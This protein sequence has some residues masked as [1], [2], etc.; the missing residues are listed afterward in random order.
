MSGSWHRRELPPRV[1]SYKGVPSSYILLDSFSVRDINK[2]NN[3][4]DNIL[5]FHWDYYQC[6]AF[7]RLKIHDSIEKS[8]LS[9]AGPFRFSKW[10]RVV[11]Y[12]YSLD[13]FSTV[14]TL[15]DIGGRFNIGDI[16]PDIFPP[17]PA[18]YIAEN[19]LTALEEVLCQKI[20][21]GDEQ[22]ALNYILADPSSMTNV[23]VSGSLESIIDLNK[24]EKLKD[25]VDLIKG[26]AI[27]PQIIKAIQKLRLPFPSLIKTLPKL[28]DVLLAKNWREWPMQYDVPATTQIFGQLV[29]KAG[30]EGILYPSKFSEKNCLVIFPQNFDDVSFVELDDPAP[31]QV[32]MTKLDAKTWTQSPK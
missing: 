8:L 16:N 27:S 29:N 6:L 7:Q 10:Q 2:W 20:N 13:P 18:L 19:K 26:F 15:N 12:K 30:I 9:A 25:F 21:P 5:K 31:Q 4:R 23:S 28:M 32:K 17:F 22:K 1:Q 3:L 14:G 11:R 24:P